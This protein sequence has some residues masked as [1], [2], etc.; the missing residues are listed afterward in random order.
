MNEEESLRY[1]FIRIREKI[2]ALNGIYLTLYSPPN[3]PKSRYYPMNDFSNKE[4]Y[5]L[6]YQIYME[7]IGLL[8]L[9]VINQRKRF[10][11]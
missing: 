4:K 8:N 9:W 1:E 2:D 6:E 11:V 3:K 5:P 7:E 10:Y